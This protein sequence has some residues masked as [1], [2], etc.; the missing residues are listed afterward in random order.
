MSYSVDANILLYASDSNSPWHSQAS[1]FLASCVVR[2]EF[3]CL[4]W[5]TLMAYL[6]T[7][8]HPRIFAAPLSPRQAEAN[9][10]S[11]PGLPRARVVCE[12]DRFWSAYRSLTGETPV[13]GNLVPGARLAAVLIEHGVRTLYSHD[14][15]FLKFSTVRVE[16]PFAP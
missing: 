13:R 10:E 11:L 15:D 2:S 6:R 4:T 7:A 8:T 1:E 3:F 16:N 12:G 14:R 9:V 5:P